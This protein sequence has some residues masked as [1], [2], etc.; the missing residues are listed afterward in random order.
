MIN[1]VKHKNYLFGG[2]FLF[3]V[4][5]LKLTVGNGNSENEHFRW[6]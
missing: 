6:G 4:F 1:V 2:L 5:R 3:N